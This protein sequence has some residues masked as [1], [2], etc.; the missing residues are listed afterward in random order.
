MPFKQNSRTI[1]DWQTTNDGMVN[2]N[3]KGFKQS[4]NRKL[5][6]GGF[7]MWLKKEEYRRKKTKH[8]INCSNLF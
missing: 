7:D 4:E 2:Q 8:T 6:F 5:G 3:W 1:C